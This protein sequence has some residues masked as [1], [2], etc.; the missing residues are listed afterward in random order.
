MESKKTSQ[1]VDPVVT[2]KKF[3][4]EV[5]KFK[6][7][8]EAYRKKGVICYRIEDFS[9]FLLFCV[10]HVN[11]Q[12][13]AFSV[14]IDYE[15]WDIEPP[16]IKFIDP[17]TDRL[18]AREQIRIKFF[19]VKH[20][21]NIRLNIRGEIMEQDLLQGQKDVLPFFCIPGVKEYHD[22]PAHSGDS[23]LLHRL[24]S[25]GELCVLIDQLYNHSIAQT[26][27][28]SLNAQISIAGFNTDIEKLRK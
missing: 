22:H 13:I 7:L 2:K 24:N 21:N 1:Y 4:E 18:L 16:S 8:E 17:F 9:V 25:E 19:Q 10:P 14:R 12:G 23:W 3:L 20:K 15:N 11:P 27:G 26:S 6:E 5:N 28:Y